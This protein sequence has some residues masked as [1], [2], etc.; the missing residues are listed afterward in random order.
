M[1]V[2]KSSGV[3]AHARL[4]VGLLGFVFSGAVLVFG[5][6]IIPNNLGLEDNRYFVQTP[7]IPLLSI[8]LIYLAIRRYRTR[9]QFEDREIVWRRVFGTSTIATSAIEYIK[10]VENKKRYYDV[11]LI[12]LKGQK[13]ELLPDGD[14]AGGQIELLEALDYVRVNRSDARVKD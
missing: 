11:H 6:Q 7:F 5:Y 1:I 13:I 8:A 3:Q 2:L 14:V 4:L 9:V 10:C 12:G